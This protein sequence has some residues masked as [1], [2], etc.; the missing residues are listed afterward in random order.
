MDRMTAMTGSDVETNANSNRTFD[1][2]ITL[3]DEPS[4]DLSHPPTIY[5]S[6]SQT[7][8]YSSI[9][10]LLD[11]NDLQ[12]LAPPLSVLAVA[13]PTFS[14]CNRP[15]TSPQTISALQQC[16]PSQGHDDDTLTLGSY[17]PNENDSE[18]RSLG[19]HYLALPITAQ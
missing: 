8:L 10:K 4:I 18:P 17:K 9:D 12:S 1:D 2:F 15:Y 3:W 19:E 5:T 11:S 7:R 13:Q 14:T 6:P 16:S